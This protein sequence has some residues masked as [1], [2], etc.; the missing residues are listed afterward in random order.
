MRQILVALSGLLIT[1]AQA[2]TTNP[3]ADVKFEQVSEG[4]QSSQLFTTDALRGLVV[5]VKDF[6]VGPGKAAPSIPTKG[7][8]VTELKSGVVETAIDGQTAQR[9]P[10]DFWLVSPGQRYAIKST[11]SMAVLHVVTFTKP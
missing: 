2:P 1:V 8:A 3:A 5:E 11:G 9:K 10:G 4:V 6:I 7:F